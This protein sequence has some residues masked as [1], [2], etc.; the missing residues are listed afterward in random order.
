MSVQSGD[1]RDKISKKHL[2]L[3]ALGVVA[4]IAVVYAVIKNNNNK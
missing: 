2:L 3:G 1:S 4:A